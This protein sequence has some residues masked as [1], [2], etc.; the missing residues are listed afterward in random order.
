VAEI[1]DFGLEIGVALGKNLIRGR[2][3]VD[4]DAE[5]PE[6]P[7]AILAEPELELHRHEGESE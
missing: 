1:P 4:F 2:L 7:Q 5:L 6:R 3:F